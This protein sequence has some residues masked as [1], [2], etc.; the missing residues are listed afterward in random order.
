MR[1]AVQ[2]ADVSNATTLMQVVTSTLYSTHRDVAVSFF[3]VVFIHSV[4]SSRVVQI[5]RLLH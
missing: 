5:L 1:Y 2:S 4:Y 3:N